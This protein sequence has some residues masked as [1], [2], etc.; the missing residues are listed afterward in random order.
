MSMY[1]FGI[2]TVVAKRTDLANQPPSFMGVMQDIQVDLD[3]AGPGNSRGRGL[4]RVE[5]EGQGKVRCTPLVKDWQRLP[6]Y[7]EWLALNAPKPVVE[8]E[9]EPE[10]EDPSR[11]DIVKGTVRLCKKPQRIKPGASKSLKVDCGVNLFEFRNP[12]AIDLMIDPV[13]QG[14][15]LL[16]VPMVAEESA[17]N[18]S[19]FPNELNNLTSQ[20]RHGRRTTPETVPASEGI[21]IPAR[22]AEVVALFDPLLQKSGARLLSGD[23][24]SLAAACAELSDIPHDDLLHGLMSGPS[25][26]AARPISSPK[27]VAKIIADIRHNWDHRDKLPAVPDFKTR[28]PTWEENLKIIEEAK[29]KERAAKLRSGS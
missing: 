21:P 25:P 14:G 13:V 12:L 9:D 11:P 5:R 7:A 20:T 19:G 8:S 3:Q 23:S 26:R 18:K 22:S 6:D 1:T 16:C 24:S 10:A 28:K 29:A 27:H 2:G 17:E 15:R 4:M